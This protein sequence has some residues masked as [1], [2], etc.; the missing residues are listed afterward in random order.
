MAPEV[1]GSFEG[2]HQFSTNRSTKNVS[3][4]SVHDINSIID[5]LI[6]KH[7]LNN[8]EALSDLIHEHHVRR[9]NPH[10][11][12]PE[13]LPKSVIEALY[14]L[15]IDEEKIGDLEHM[16]DVVFHYTKVADWE[17]ML[18]GISLDTVIPIKIVLDYIYYHDANIEAHSVIFEQLIPGDSFKAYPI[19][20]INRAIGLTRE[21][22]D[23]LAGEA[24]VHVPNF[25]TTNGTIVLEAVRD[26]VVPSEDF[27]FA[28][29]GLDD[30]NK[31]VID[32]PADTSDIR[33]RFYYEGVLK[34]T[35]S[36]PFPTDPEFVLALGFD[37]L[38]IGLSMDGRTILRTATDFRIPHVNKLYLGDKSSVGLGLVNRFTV[39][40]QTATDL[41]LVGLVCHQSRPVP[42]IAVDSSGCW[43]FRN[44]QVPT[45]VQA[46]QDE[47]FAYGIT[48]ASGIY[49]L[50]VDGVPTPTFVSI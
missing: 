21:Q 22:P 19:F 4:V 14:E 45:S 17:T 11:L 9:D 37:K 2:W 8:I 15:W 35:L 3:G 29:L 27:H 33:V 49:L 47:A 10:K 26:M 12:T 43:V 30:G 18:E 38:S 16:K 13:Q 23:S 31:I 48:L 7:N 32:H 36:E 20:S 46:Y 41:Q 5:G 24:F 40:N 44:G 34:K 28:T 39:Y 6:K 1:N 50:M 25:N 42:S